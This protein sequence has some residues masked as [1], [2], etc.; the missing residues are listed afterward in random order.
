MGKNG[1]WN[2]IV[3]EKDDGSLKRII[4]Y[5]IFITFY[6]VTQGKCIMITEQFVEQS[7]RKG[8]IGFGLTEEVFKVLC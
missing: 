2:C 6:S 8:Y 1:N 7:H 5:N 4:G 3:A